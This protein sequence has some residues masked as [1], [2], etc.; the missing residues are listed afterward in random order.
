MQS[1]VIYLTQYRERKF[2]YSET[3]LNRNLCIKEPVFGAKLFSLQDLEYP[4]TK[5]QVPVLKGIFLQ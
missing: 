4:P 1:K 3:H 5:L 2:K